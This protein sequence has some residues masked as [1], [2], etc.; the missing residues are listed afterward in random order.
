MSVKNRPVSEKNAS[1]IEVSP[2]DFLIELV[3]LDEGQRSVEDGK[4]FLKFPCELEKMSLQPVF[5]CLLFANQIGNLVPS[6]SKYRPFLRLQTGRP[7]K[8]IGFSPESIMEFCIRCE[9]NT[10]GWN[11]GD[12]ISLSQVE[13]RELNEFTQQ[14]VQILQRQENLSERES[15]HSFALTQ[16]YLFVG[17]K[18][19]H[20]T[21]SPFK[22]V[23]M[24]TYSFHEKSPPEI[25]AVACWK[26]ANQGLVDIY[27]NNHVLTEFKDDLSECAD[28]NIEIGGMLAG[29]C[30][31]YGDYKYLRID[32]YIAFDQYKRQEG[33]KIQVSVQ[34]VIEKQKI[35]Q[36][37]GKHCMGMIHNHPFKGDDTLQMSSDDLYNMFINYPHPYMVSIIAGTDAL[38]KFP[39]CSRNHSCSWFGSVCHSCNVKSSQ[40]FV[41]GFAT[42]CWRLDGTI[43]RTFLRVF[44]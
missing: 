13:V 27:I 39:N 24:S 41:H 2:D 28:L 33:T 20:H 37:E 23:Q 40:Q 15:R 17:K 9:S 6:D 29:D 36:S 19:Q 4:A 42:Y 30:Y 25:S 8:K 38:E 32:S 18:R 14:Y 3:K 22:S 1:S 16:N 21:E 12:E 34:E 11:S 35:I 31:S 7:A 43:G 10:N 5:N 26:G 44:E